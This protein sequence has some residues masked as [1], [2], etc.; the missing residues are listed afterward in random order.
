M[1]TY[2]HIRAAVVM[3]ALVCAVRVGTRGPGRGARRRS[4]PGGAHLLDD[5]VWPEC[6]LKTAVNFRKLSRT[7]LARTSLHYNTIMQSAGCSRGQ[8]NPT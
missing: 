7:S 8:L 1:R 6:V 3:Y 4:K 2:L 5:E